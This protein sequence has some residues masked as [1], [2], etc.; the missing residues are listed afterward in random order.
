ML[1]VES[2]F[3]R[4]GLSVI[5]AGGKAPLLIRLTCVLL[6]ASALLSLLSTNSSSSHAATTSDEP[7]LSFWVTDGNVYASLLSP[8]GRILYLGGDFKNVGPNTGHGV[9]IDTV[10]GKPLPSFPRVEGDVYSCVPDGAGGWFIGG[11]FNEVAGVA[12]NRI[13]HILPDLTL[14]GSFGPGAD[15]PVRTLLLSG[16]TLYA[17]GEF[18]SIGGQPLSYIVALDA[19]PASP[20]YGQ[21][22]G[23]KPGAD[24]SVWTLALS[25]NTLY[26]GG[27]FTSIGGQPRDYIAALDADP[28]SPAYGQ[29]TGFNP[30][31]DSSVWT[32]ALTGDTLYV[33]GWFTSIGGQPRNRIAALDADPASPAYGKAMGFNPDANGAVLTIAHSGTTLYAGGLFN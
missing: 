7:D 20:A 22:T 3:S 18:S 16:N 21:A 29:A 25:G 33:G 10:T 24:G 8:D 12:R 23:F 6:L 13:A 26:A 1:S 4:R 19:D 11:D 30:D 15:G 28:A 31:A 9:P 27:G 14:D 5:S 17:G 2:A 32:L